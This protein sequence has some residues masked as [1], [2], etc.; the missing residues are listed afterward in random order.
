MSEFPTPPREFLLD[1]LSDARVYIRG[2]ADPGRKETHHAD[3]EESPVLLQGV[4]VPPPTR[5][6]QVSTTHP[7]ARD[8][9][10]Q[11]SSTRPTQEGA[12]QG[13]LSSAWEVERTR[14]VG[15]PLAVK[16]C[17]SCGR[18]VKLGGPTHCPS[19][20]GKLLLEACTQLLHDDD[21][22]KSGLPRADCGGCLTM[23]AFRVADT[24]E[25]MPALPHSVF[26]GSAT[27]GDCASPCAFGSWSI[28][29]VESLR[30][31][32]QGHGVE[33]V[34]A[35]LAGPQRIVVPTPRHSEDL[36]F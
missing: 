11:G 32:L 9:E 16:R 36:P 7:V 31:M 2:D 19:C 8:P 33:L 17:H 18:T 23:L 30:A 1:L 10:A 5:G 20:G 3:Q 34:L 15:K 13:T 21:V 26:C 27:K 14:V 12:K 24:G 28:T 22:S 29:Y 25:E 6:W 35:G 4:S